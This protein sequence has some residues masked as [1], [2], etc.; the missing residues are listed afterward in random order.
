V[1]Q[2]RHVAYHGKAI[3]GALR[4]QEANINVQ[5]AAL[6][7]SSSAPHLDGGTIDGRQSRLVC[8]H[9]AGTTPHT[10]DAASER[11]GEYTQ[12]W[13]ACNK[14]CFRVSA[15]GCDRHVQHAGAAMCSLWLRALR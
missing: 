11:L 13:S 6:N 15:G 12:A 14:G 2:H 8:R 10:R 7:S 5:K 3:I 1:V 9:N 4:N